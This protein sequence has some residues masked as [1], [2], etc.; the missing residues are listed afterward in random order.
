MS[1]NFIKHREYVAIFINQ[2][3]RKKII[4]RTAF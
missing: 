2:Q 4:S 3:K 1:E